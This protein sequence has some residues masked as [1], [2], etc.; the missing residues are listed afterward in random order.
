MRTACS[1]VSARTGPSAHNAFKSFPVCRWMHTALEA[2][3]EVVAAHQLAATEIE[4]VTVHTSRRHGARFHGSTAPATMVDA[5]FSLPFAIAAQALGIAPGAAWYRPETLRRAD[6]LG[7]ARR[8]VATVDPDID[9]LMTGP[10]RRPAA[11]RHRA[12][13]WRGF[14]P[15]G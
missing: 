7:F 3:A 2:F 9:A 14:M 1:R 11:T 10:L 15:R 8:V 13:A 6:V 5:Q 4:Q 12:G